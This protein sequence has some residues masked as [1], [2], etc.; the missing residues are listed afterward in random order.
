MTTGDVGALAG[1][2]NFRDLGGLPTTD[3]HRTRSGRLFRSDTL[4]ALTAPDVAHLVQTLGVAVVIDL[5]VAAEAV[6]QGRGP[7]AG[8]PVGYVNIPLDDA[9][10]RDT[11]RGTATPVGSATETASPT[12]TFYLNFLESDSP[13]LALA[14]Q[15]L[16]VSLAHPV[17]VHCAAGK[18]RTGLVIAL[19]LDLVGVRTEAIIADYMVSARNIDRVVARFRTWPRYRDRMA[20]VDPQF[21]RVEEHVIRAFLAELRG[22]Y[23]G[24]R[25]WAH[26]RGVPDAVLDL[27]A[28]RL[29]EA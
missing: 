14:L 1:A 9:P 22:R 18:D 25:G 6:E 20:V 2:F 4:Q 24:A 5:R 28:A 21:Y 27:L 11:P 23:G 10:R 29:V 3:G 7:L 16:A 26:R 15:I 17:V 13:A 8:S 12:V 19:A